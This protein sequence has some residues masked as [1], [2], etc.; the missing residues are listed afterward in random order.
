MSRT[1]AQNPSLVSGQGLCGR[2]IRN[3]A[4]LVNLQQRGQIGKHLGHC[5]EPQ[6][7]RRGQPQR[8]TQ[9]SWEDA[10]IATSSVQSEGAESK[11]PHP[12][13]APSPNREHCPLQRQ[14]AQLAVC[15]VQRALCSV[16]CE[17]DS[18]QCAAASYLPRPSSSDA[19]LVGIACQPNISQNH[20]TEH[21]TLRH[22]LFHDS[23]HAQSS[24]KKHDTPCVCGVGGYED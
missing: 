14:K 21:N 24:P 7:R 15:C 23:N 6:R 8:G 13:P 3:R 4:V 19:M 11:E 18:V 5:K 1:T 17:V 9:K 16:L 20:P 10:L 12:S 22:K 2:H